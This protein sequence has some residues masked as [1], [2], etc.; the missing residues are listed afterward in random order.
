M[1]IYVNNNGTWASPKLVNVNKS[2]TWTAT[3]KVYVNN[4]GTWQLVYIYINITSNQSNY[5]LYTAAGSPS[6][7]VTCYCVINS[8]VQITAST[9]AN[10]AFTVGSFPSG[11]KVFLVNKGTIAGAGGDASGKGVSTATQ[12]IV[13]TAHNVTAPAEANGGPAF[14]ANF[15]ISID[16]GSGTIGGGGGGGGAGGSTAVDCACTNCG[17]V[18]IAGFSAGGGGAGF[19]AGGKSTNN[20]R[21]NQG[22]TI[23]N[24]NVYQLGSAG[25]LSAGG[26]IS[27]GN[28][29]AGGA[30]GSAGIK[31]T[32]TASCG[33]TYTNQYSGGAG[34]A[35]GAATAGNA[36]ITWIS[37]GTRL[38]ALN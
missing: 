13:Q 10:Y 20:W 18:N 15:A 5:N 7:P 35:A 11:S 23:A 14:N 17:G 29:G 16:N 34:G 1:T 2:G 27:G 33:T 31:G 37:T 9:P 6:R 4:G 21:N 8:G 3:P 24:L 28:A 25:T 32:N 22:Y 36:N 30:L 38:G 12:A 26:N 19:G